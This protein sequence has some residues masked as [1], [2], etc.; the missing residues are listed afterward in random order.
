MVDVETEADWL[1]RN[2]DPMQPPSAETLVRFHLGADAI[3]L[4]RMAG[5]DGQ[6]IVEDGRDLIL[7]RPRLPPERRREVLFHEL[8]EVRL[9]RI[10]Y[11]KQDVEAR[12]NQLGAALVAPRLPFR[13]TVAHVGRRFG[14]LARIFIATEALV[15]IRYGEATGRP[16]VVLTPT[17]VH[18]RGDDNAWPPEPVLRALA[19]TNRLP[20]GIELV[21]LGDDPRC[22]V[23]LVG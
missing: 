11:D 21:P 4:A 16:T 12:A 6:A 13:A 23:L 10:G 19:K 14:E 7:V 18:V 3:R 22:A 15:A 9:A 5:R 8:A 1:L 20:P 2:F 17:R